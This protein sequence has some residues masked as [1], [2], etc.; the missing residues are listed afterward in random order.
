MADNLGYTEGSG[1]NIATDEVAGAHLQRVKLD[2]GA[3]GAAAPLAAD[4][5]AD[6][7]NPV[8]IGGKFNSAVPSYD[9]GDR[10]DLQ[11]DV[12]GNLKVTL[13]TGIAGENWTVNRL[14]TEENYTYFRK[15]ADGQIMSGGGYLLSVNIARTGSVA[16]AGVLTIYDSASETGTVIYSEYIDTDTKPHTIPIKSNVA[17]GIYVGFDATLAGIQVSGAYRVNP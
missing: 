5:S 6:T 2:Q 13:A 7:G 15:T 4:N 11:V 14:F 17:S 8:K 9:D 12:N 1:K 3:E 16:T 10:A